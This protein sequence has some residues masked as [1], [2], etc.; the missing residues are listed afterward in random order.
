MVW[1]LKNIESKT[2]QMISEVIGKGLDEL[3][4]AARLN[5]VTQIIPLYKHVE[6][7]IASQY[8]QTLMLN[9]CKIQS[10]HWVFHST[11]ADILIFWFFPVFSCP[12]WVS[13][14]SLMTPTPVLDWQEWNLMWSSAIV[15]HS[16]QDLLWCEYGDA[17]LLT[18]DENWLVIILLHHQSGHF[19]L[20][21]T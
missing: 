15:V 20:I 18:R 11:Q 10:P 17:F 21:L 13:L 3:I 16:L 4:W 14:C 2:V 1:K 8:A 9:S 5:T 6:P 7:K 19:H 12:V